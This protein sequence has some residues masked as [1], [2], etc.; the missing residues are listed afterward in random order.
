MQEKILFWINEHSSS[1]LD[2]LFSSITIL[3]ETSILMII[4]ATL[5]WVKDKKGAINLTISLF[6]ALTT[7]GFLKAYFKVKRPFDVL[8][9]DA[10]RHSTASGYS[11]PS[12][13]TISGAT[14]YGFL[15]KNFKTLRTFLFIMIILI[16]FSRIY[17]RVH[18]PLDVLVSLILGL[19]FAF[20]IS[21]IVDKIQGPIF[22]FILSVL[23]LIGLI[24]SL[25]LYKEDPRAYYDLIKT[26]TLSLSATIGLLLDHFFLQFKMPTRA[27]I[28]IVVLGL[29]I[30]TFIVASKHLF[31]SIGETL[32]FT[33][34]RY[35]LLGLFVTFLW[36]L[37]F[38][39]LFKAYNK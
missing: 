9:I 15:A 29:I 37:S 8:K 10:V 39:K 23:S 27:K 33:I 17:L 35:S 20:I 26:L 25:L 4:I 19:F 36:P 1:F 2:F 30:S 38:N 22:Y 31:G 21:S 32:Y 14:T 11:F 18:W 3:A 6:L 7:M 13:H 12:G 28:R 34:I 24:G 16:A 5:Y